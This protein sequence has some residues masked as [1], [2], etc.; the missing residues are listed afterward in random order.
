MLSDDVGEVRIG[1]DAAD[2]RDLG[3]ARP[4]RCGARLGD[5]AGS[6]DHGIPAQAHRRRTGVGRPPGHRELAPG[7]ALHAGHDPD[8]HA[9]VLEH[10]PLLDVQ[11]DERVR[12]RGGRARG[13]AR[14]ADPGELVSEPAAVGR[15]G[16]E[17]LLDTEPSDVHER[18]E[19]VRWESGALFVGEER[20]LHRPSQLD[21][22]S[23]QRL[24]HLEPGE[25]AQVAVE[26]ASGGNRVD[27][28]SD[29]HCGR[30]R[31]GAG[32]GGDDVADAVDRHGHPEIVHPRHD[33]IPPGP[34]LIGQRQTADAPLS[35]RTV[36]RT[37]LPERLE[38][39]PQPIAVD[40]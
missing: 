25:D 11:L 3:A 21:T 4:P 6:H 36:H 37:D 22:G 23:R 35:V 27:V 18:A 9:L 32:V 8:R 33:K 20:D 1:V 19:H 14:V 7:D 17:C 2:G 16:V 13:R 40:P 12:E 39:C 34:V 31:I 15:T 30:R 10:G 28:G 5:D 38:P 26:A 24:D 29:H